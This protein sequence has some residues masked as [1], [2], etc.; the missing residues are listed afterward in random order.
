MNYGYLDDNCLE[1]YKPQGD[2]LVQYYNDHI[3]TVADLLG[4]DNNKIPRGFIIVLEQ[5]EKAGYSKE[6]R[7][8]IYRFQ[9]KENILHD[10]GRI[11]HEAA[12]VV[13]NYPVDISRGHPSWC[14][15]E[16][17]ADYCRSFIDNDFN[18]EDD[19]KCDP[20]EYGYRDNA[21]FLIWLNN[22]F[23]NINII[24]KL[25]KLIHNDPNNFMNAH[26][27]LDEVLKELTDEPAIYVLREYYEHKIN[28]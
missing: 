3:E 9:N 22:K 2:E 24:H 5:G 16:G 27:V 11:I 1:D 21:H 20:I 8:I 12:H 7:K 6:Y 13:Q 17:L 28:L 19:L 25:H 23:R 10:K 4:V 14:W 15:M 26:E 18:L